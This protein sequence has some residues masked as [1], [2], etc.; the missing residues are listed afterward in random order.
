MT[1]TTTAAPADPPGRRFVWAMGALMALQAFSFLWL[2][3]ASAITAPYADIYSLITQ[4]FEE[5]DGREGLLAYLWAAHAGH[6]IVWARGLTLLDMDLFGGRGWPTIMAA[7]LALVGAAALLAREAAGAV[8][9]RSLGRSGAV[10]AAMAALTAIAAFDASQ[11]VFCV[12]P[13]TLVF[14]V[15]AIVLFEDEAATALRVCGV[16]AA[17]G[18]AFGNGV[19]LALWPVLAVMAARSGRRRVLW[20]AIV[21]GVGGVFSALYLRDIAA[22]SPSASAAGPLQRIGFALSFLGLPVSQVSAPGGQLFGALILLASLAALIAT[23]VGQGSRTARIAAAF[24][25][26]GLIATALAAAGRVE[27][28]AGTRAP[29][30]YA[31]LLTPLHVGLLLFALPLAARIG[32]ARALL[33][34]CA[35]LLALGQAELARNDL[36]TAK[37]IRGAIARWRGGERSAEVR[38]LVFYDAP[39]AEA[40]DA[41]LRREGLFP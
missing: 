3:D 1:D 16:L 32:R 23:R 12:Y 6:H 24:I 22:L 30:R 38:A 7:V 36:V 29:V 20:T 39:A 34:A 37:T 10:V 41:R 27:V 14:A 26:F 9:D 17:I 2:V 33:L 19:G 28:A 15:L 31:P 35:A 13:F 40:V 11:P 21:V 25:L 18:A 4:A 5:R 8:A